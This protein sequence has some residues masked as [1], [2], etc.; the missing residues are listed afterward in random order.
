M[1]AK[2]CITQLFAKNADMPIQSVFNYD[3]KTETFSYKSKNGRKRMKTYTVYF[4]LKY[5]R[6]RENKNVLCVYC[7]YSLNH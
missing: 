4:H 1:S 2:Y 6:F 7:I 3:V 5:M